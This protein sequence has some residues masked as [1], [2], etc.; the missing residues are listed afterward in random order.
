MEKKVQTILKELYA[1]DPSLKE[2]EDSVKKVLARIVSDKP[3]TQFDRAFAERLKA[4][5]LE[6]PLR[7][8]EKKSFTFLPKP[9]FAFFGSA[10]AVVLVVSLV[11]NNSGLETTQQAS[12]TS[13]SANAFGSL[14]SDNTGSAPG[15]VGGR[16]AGGGVA[17]SEMLSIAP[18]SGVGDSAKMSIAAPYPHYNNYKLVYRGETLELNDSTVSVLRRVKPGSGRTDL[19]RSLSSLNFGGVNLGSFGSAGLTSF[20]LADDGVNGYIVNVNVRD[21]VVSVN[22]NWQTWYPCPNG[23]CEQHSPLTQDDVPSDETLISMANAFLSEHG[24]SLASYGS[25]VVEDAWRSVRPLLE[26]DR[27][28]QMYVPENVSVVY[29]L[30]IEGQGV[31]DGSGT[32]VGLRVGI[33]IRKN[34]VSSAWPIQDNNFEASSYAAETDAQRIVSYA[35]R[36][37]SYDPFSKDVK[38]LVLGTPARVLL[39]HYSYDSGKGVS[40]ELYVPALAFPVQD[41]PEDFYPKTVVVPLVKDMLDSPMYGGPIH[42]MEK[43]AAVSSGEI[44]PEPT[45]LR[46]EE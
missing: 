8:K 44:M 5:L 9:M 10:L 21:G 37:T 14:S 24:V 35:Q 13:L 11:V 29:P 43:D 42:I 23:V 38:E 40:T 6:Q 32:K 41:V 28:T 34:K 12:I 4:D 2:H 17:M 19:T 22:Q 16:G 3:D 1:I 26:G 31:I 27:T 45:V 15:P 30:T 33:D 25:P 18:G 36:M 46:I 39:Q 7:Q 20:E